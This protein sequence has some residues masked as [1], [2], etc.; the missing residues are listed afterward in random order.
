MYPQDIGESKSEPWTYRNR[1]V[2]SRTYSGRIV[3]NRKKHYFTLGDARRII[4]KLEPPLTA[5][6]R[7]WVDELMTFL[8]ETTIRLMNIMLPLLTENDTRNLYQVIF[9]FLELFFRIDTTSDSLKYWATR[10]IGDIA[11]RVGL[12][13]TINKPL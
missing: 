12:N 10:L 5:T 6:P 3:Y 9:E 11:A 7:S 4:N 1:I 13:V 2:P 8:R